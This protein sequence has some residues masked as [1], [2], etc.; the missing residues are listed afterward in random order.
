MYR[1]EVEATSARLASNAESVA[2]R[3]RELQTDAQIAMMEKDQH[4]A[5]M[6][7]QGIEYANNMR[8]KDEMVEELKMKL[9]DEGERLKRVQAL[10]D[11]DKDQL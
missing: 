2:A 5:Q 10:Q 1:R 8:L 9:P 11:V 7:K 3:S 4:L 6:Q